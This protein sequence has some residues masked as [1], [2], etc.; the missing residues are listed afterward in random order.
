MLKRVIHWFELEP[1]GTLLS[2]DHGAMSR[3]VQAGALTDPKR[4]RY[5]NCRVCKSSLPI[6]VQSWGEHLVRCTLCGGEVDF[7]I[8]FQS[9]SAKL[10]WLPNSLAAQIDS[11]LNPAVTLIENRLW[12]LSEAT[13]A[14]TAVYLLRSTINLDLE[15]ILAALN[16]D[17]DDG[18]RLILTTSPFRNMPEPTAETTFLPLDEVAHMEPEGIRLDARS[19]LPQLID[20]VPLWFELPPPYNR[21]T[22]A[23]ETLPL[24]RRQPD[25]MRL[26]R[27]AH[28][29]GQKK[30]SWRALL[31]RAGYRDVYTSLAQVFP[32]EV[33]RFIET[34]KDDVWIRKAPLPKSRAGP[35]RQRKNNR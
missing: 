1:V 7:G 4:T 32:D 17:F 24:R 33:F 25:F 29:A 10:S 11:S 26:L 18:R 23:G 21:L 6:Q 20:Q 12:R 15:P 2:Y 3:F 27:L 13:S 16:A 22:L 34:S 14:T 5:A 28:A 9:V 31:R 8:E 19:L 30:A 35:H